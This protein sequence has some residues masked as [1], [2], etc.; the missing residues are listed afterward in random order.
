MPL[1]PDWSWL[2]ARFGPDA[3]PRLPQSRPC[4]PSVETLDGRVLLSVSASDFT[5][6]KVLDKST[7]LVQAEAAALDPVDGESADH[8]HKDWFNE[9]G[10]DFVKVNSIFEQYE[11]DILADKVAP[12]ERAGVTEQLSLNFAKIEYL[13]SKI[14]PAGSDGQLLPAVQKVREIAMGDGSVIPSENQG[15][16]G[17][18]SKITPES[19]TSI[20]ADAR[21]IFVKMNDSFW[22]LDEYAID[23]K[24]DLIRGVRGDVATKQ[25]DDKVQKEYLKIKLDQVF[26]S[27]YLDVQLKGDLEQAI[28]NEVNA[29]NGIVHP[30][31]NPDLLFAG[32]VTSP[33]GA[34]DTIV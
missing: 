10:V 30:V 13:A 33:G 23:F 1:F 27:S 11:D 25:F 15:L 32:G 6:P 29:V 31:T 34:G 4:L 7:P 8:K 26:V 19:I 12:G 22:K 14:D 24:L 20:P 28:E 3:G 9:L 2:P 21:A 18:L 16:L 17:D 5:I